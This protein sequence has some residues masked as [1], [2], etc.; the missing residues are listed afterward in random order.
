MINS[1]PAV[2]WVGCG[3]CVGTAAGAFVGATVDGFVGWRV[4]AAGGVLVK[5]GVLVFV[6]ARV[7]VGG[8]GVGVGLEVA[9]EV[10][11]TSIVIWTR[12]GASGVQVGRVLAGEPAQPAKS[13]QTIASRKTR[14]IGGP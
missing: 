12:L 3:G 8:T 5:A 4:A 6:A 2:G 14:F 11:G 9:V 13:A 1:I 10:G 7:N